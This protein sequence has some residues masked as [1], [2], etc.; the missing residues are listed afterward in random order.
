MKQYPKIEYHNKRIF[1]EP[2][3]AMDKIDG[4]NL[5]FEWGWKRGFY[6][7]GTRSTM[8]DRNSQP[9]GDGIDIFLNKYGE[10]LNRIFRDRYG[11]VESFVVFGEYV[12]ENSF[13][14]QH[15]E[16]DIKDVILFDV[17]AYKRGFVGPEEFLK[18]FG[19]L[20]IPR[21][22]YQG[23]YNDDLIKS[24]R[25]NRHGLKEGVIVKG[26][27]RKEVWMAKIK[28]NEWLEKVRE[29]FGEKYLM[30]ELNNDKTL[31]S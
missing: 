24:V 26:Q 14:G 25:E 3:V 27:N 12:G 15:M 22:V 8:I 6:K 4:S 29:K 28:T 9:F 31:M 7:F 13:A 20:D 17:S 16:S 2:C 23:K 18:N 1:G 19:R 30:E 10:D 5:R 11:K 21:V